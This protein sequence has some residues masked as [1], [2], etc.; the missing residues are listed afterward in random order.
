M[1]GPD[2]IDLAGS[3]NN[4]GTVYSRKGDYDR[5]LEN[6]NKSLAI[7]KKV[8]GPE[9]LDVAASFNNIGNVY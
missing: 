8:L 4:I 1:L 2:S 5:A 9:S 3:I 6:L 7:R